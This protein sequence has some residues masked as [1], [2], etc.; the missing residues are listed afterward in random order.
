MACTLA[1][2]QAENVERISSSS[3]SANVNCSAWG[4]EDLKAG[5]EEDREESVC[6]V[7]I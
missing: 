7:E 3:A 5:E 4:R 2:H 1:E 6:I